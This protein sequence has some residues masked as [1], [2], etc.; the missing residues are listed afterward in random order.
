MKKMIKIT[1]ISILLLSSQVSFAQANINTGG[2]YLQQQQQQNNNNNNVN[3]NPHP[4]GPPDSHVTFSSSVNYPPLRRGNW[5]VPDHNVY[6]ND[7][8]N[9]AIGVGNNYLYNNNS[10]SGYSYP[11][12]PVQ[13]TPPSNSY[14]TTTTPEPED[15]NN[16]VSALINLYNSYQTQ[17]AN[18]VQMYN[19][20]KMNHKD[21]MANGYLTDYHYK[22]GIM[23]DLYS[24][25]QNMQAT[26]AN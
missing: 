10:Y 15:S 20:Y 1:F 21:D 7:N 14:N 4:V 16:G 23:N 3:N 5:D 26:G 17:V 24:E 11:N 13:V 12:Y 18:D 2:V 22:I 19:F 9:L 25:I 8:N 6:Y